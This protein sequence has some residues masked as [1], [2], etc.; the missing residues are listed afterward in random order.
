MHTIKFTH[1]TSTNKS[2]PIWNLYSETL[3]GNTEY[4]W[5]A[6]TKNGLMKQQF[7]SNPN[8]ILTGTYITTKDFSFLHVEKS[9]NKNESQI[10]T[11]YV[12]NELKKL[13]KSNEIATFVKSFTKKSKCFNKLSKSFDAL[14]V[15]KVFTIHMKNELNIKIFAKIAIC[16]KDCHSYIN[17]IVGLGATHIDVPKIPASKIIS[18]KQQNIFRYPCKKPGYP[19]ILSVAQVETLPNTISGLNNLNL[20]VWGNLQSFIKGIGFELV[21]CHLSFNDLMILLSLNSK[22]NLFVQL[23]KK[24]AGIPITLSFRNFCNP[25][26][27][28]PVYHLP[29]IVYFA[30]KTKSRIITEFENEDGQECKL[31]CKIKEKVDEWLICNGKIYN[32]KGEI[33][34]T[35]IDKRY[36]KNTYSYRRPRKYLYDFDSEY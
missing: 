8:N 25:C 32:N 31:T 3:N 2:P 1:I 14:P 12:L 16:S 21:M 33:T 35:V 24:N 28:Y 19:K 6:K 15:I 10:V 36:V 7:I 4:C 22:T 18:S 30:P 5:I 13:E 20:D 17:G 23:M 9:D 26:A 27:V 34:K 29:T 11:N